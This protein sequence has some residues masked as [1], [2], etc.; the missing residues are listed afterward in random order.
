MSPS[1]KK[2]VLSGRKVYNKARIIKQSYVLHLFS[3]KEEY[4]VQKTCVF[5]LRRFAAGSD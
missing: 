3:L 2:L 1:G 4:Y 5:N